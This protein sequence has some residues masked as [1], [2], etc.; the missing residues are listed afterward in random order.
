MKVHLNKQ[1]SIS[2]LVIGCMRMS[3]WKLSTAEMV[4]FIEWC[5]ERGITTFDHADIYGGEHKNEELFGEALHMQPSLREKIQIITKCD[6]CVPNAKN[7]GINT[8]FFNTDKEYILAQVNESLIKLQCDYVDILLIHMFDLL[9]D[10]AE[11]NETLQQLKNEG[12]VKYFGLSNHNPIEFD[13]LQKHT[14]IPFVTNQFML[15]P[16][17]IENYIN[18]TMTHCLKAGISPMIWSPL[19]GGRIFKPGNPK[20]KSMRNVLESIRMELEMEHVD[21]VVYKWIFRHSSNPA[22]VLG[23][24][25]K[26]RIERAIRSVS[27]S[28]MTREQWYKI[29]IEAGYKLW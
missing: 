17:G 20:E 4:Q 5:L 21:E 29:L 28:K 9:I 19:A 14:D 11:L 10:P 16:L 2:K 23:T 15:N 22:I 12:K 26:E 13:T 25:N 3:D 7:P 6:I 24:G 1:L 8:R 18:G 27:G